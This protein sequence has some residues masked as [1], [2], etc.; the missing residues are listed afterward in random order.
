MMGSDFDHSFLLSR[1]DSQ[2][3]DQS[4]CAQEVRQELAADMPS[5]HQRVLSALT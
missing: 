1:S 4:W 3:L 2:L 5:W